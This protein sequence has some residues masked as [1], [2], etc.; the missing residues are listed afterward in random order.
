MSYTKEYKRLAIHKML[1]QPN[2]SIR[3][4]AEE[5]GVSK[6]TIWDWKREVDKVTAT[7]GGSKKRGEESPQ[8]RTAEEKLRLVLEAGRLS[9]EE[10]GAFL[11]RE[12]VH[13]AQLE[14]WRKAMVEAVEPSGRAKRSAADVKRIRELERELRRKDKALAETAALLALKKKARAIWGDEDDDTDPTSE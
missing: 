4:L 13:E 3:E 11:R 7:M 6:S 12:G 14:Q 2:A 10:L 9:G 1:T 5:L 8:D